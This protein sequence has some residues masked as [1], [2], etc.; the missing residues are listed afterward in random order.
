MRIA[1]VKLSALGD[2]VHSI[3]VLQFIKQYNQ[4]ILIDWIVE[5]RYKEI[6]ELNPYI[7]KVH[8]I[9]IQKAKNRKSIQILLSE[10]KNIRKLEAYD[11]VIDLQGLLK[12][13]IISRIIPSNETVGFDKY[14][15]RERYASLFYSVVY[16]CAYDK[17]I[18]ERNLEL[19]SFA[20]G[21][22]VTSQQIQNKLPLLFSKNEVLNEN[23]SKEKNNIVLIPGSSHPSKCYPVKKFAQLSN[24]INA[25]FFVIWGNLNEKKMAYEIK[26]LSP[27]VNVC[28]KLSLSSLI[29][30]ISK[31][32]L[33]IGPDTGPT[34]ISWAMN[35][36]SI[37]LFGATPGYRNTYETKINR[38]IES[39]SNVN[40][41]KINKS[42]YSINDIEVEQILEIVSELL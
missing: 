13:A 40:P 34:H 25:N 10:L 23:L 30:L 27:S 17:N 19:V 39:T 9:N 33:V 15:I 24:L 32:D 2:I 29:S 11:L 20:I 3:I 8:S 14:S 41:R 7:N 36:R 12:S 6:L 38:I 28:N 35:V 1:I 18:I 4:E 21:F 26:E 37:T 31:A 16:S 5:D 42:D 22:K